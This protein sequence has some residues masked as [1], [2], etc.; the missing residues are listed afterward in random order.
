M[1]YIENILKT[2]SFVYKCYSIFLNFILSLLKL[3][4]RVDNQ[5]ILFNSYG[6]KQYS[7]SPRIIYEYMLK[8]EKYK[9]FKYYWAFNDTSK[10]EIK[11]GIKV[12]NNSLKFFIIAL[13]A[14][15]WIT[16]T[17]IERGLKFKNKNTIY[18]NTWHGSPLKRIGKDDKNNNVLLKT[19]KIDVL[20]SQ[21]EYEMNILMRVFDIPKKNVHLVG[22]PRNDS[23][24]KV[25]EKEINDIKKK[26][27]LPL[28]KKIILYAP[29]FREYK[30]DSQG[31]VLAPPLNLKLWEEKLSDKYIL[32]FRA[33]YEINKILGIKE[34]NFL[35]NFTN[36]PDII[37]LLKISDILI[38]DYSSI[39]IDYSILERPIFNYVYDYDEYLSKRGLY[40]DLKKEI[41]GNFIENENKLIE[42]IV[43]LNEKKEIEKT[44]KFKEKYVQYFGHATEYIEK[45]IK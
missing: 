16:N 11:N 37:D 29:T 15:Y 30:R 33:H 24:S 26:L 43:N 6:G 41:L 22:I 39:M 3:F 21:S 34:N 20:F 23:L 14:K 1:K 31:C 27:N 44:K 18:I 8:K 45:I 19:S 12:K 32:I 35:K 2:N 28:N 36:Y 42:K 38:S 5:I 13:K 7:D 17:G 25:T 40:C 9:N 10:Y 4:I